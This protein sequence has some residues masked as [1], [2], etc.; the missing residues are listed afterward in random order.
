MPFATEKLCKA[1]GG[2]TV[3]NN[4]DLA[5][6]DGEI[7]ALLGANGAGKSTLIKCVSGAIQPDF[8]NIIIGGEAHSSLTPKEA[9]KAGVAVIYQDLA[10]AMSLNVVDNIFLGQELR[11]GPFLRRHAQ[12]EEA[13]HW[14]EKLGVQLDPREDLSKIGSAQL[15]LVEIVKSLRANPE[16]LILDEPTASLTERESLQL[17]Q[18]LLTLK[19]QNLPLLYVTHRLTEVFQLADRVSVLRGGRVV[20]SESVADV[21]QNDLVEAIVGRVLETGPTASEI[22]RVEHTA[23]LLKV[24]KLLASGIGP[25]DLDLHPG[26]ILG[27]FGLVGSGR[28]EL[29]ETLF[30]GHRRYGGTVNLAGRSITVNSPA[31]AVDAGI[32]LVPSDRLRKS[33]L[34]TMTS[35]DNMLLPS[36]TRLAKMGIRTAMSERRVFDHVAGQIN[37]QPLR[38]NLEAQRFSGGNQQKLVIGRWLHDDHPC[39]VLLLDEPT[40]GVDVGAR[41]DLYAALRRFVADDGRG[42]IVTSSEPDELAQLAHRVL[43]LSG[44]SIVGQLLGTEITEFALLNLAHKNEQLEE[45]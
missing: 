20:L 30:G 21:T 25:I 36:F 10:L 33:I 8:G 29:L 24:S 3:L 32:A 43:I 45:A 2:V 17:Q 40:Q 39:S 11:R 22:S 7:H 14:L 18:Y 35:A 34:S 44:G 9:H 31:N 5:V 19:K 16:V 6:N 42:I 38:R 41:Q 12:Y 1:Y 37:L 13:K 4:V 28:T 26:E 23:P 15:Q 27:V